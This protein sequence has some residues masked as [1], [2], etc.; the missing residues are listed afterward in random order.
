MVQVKI[1]TV[2]EWVA[3]IL[4]HLT[5]QAKIRL[6]CDPPLISGDAAFPER[7]VVR[8]YGQCFVS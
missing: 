4:G 1:L 7:D 6:T 2:T 8:S 3:F 5:L